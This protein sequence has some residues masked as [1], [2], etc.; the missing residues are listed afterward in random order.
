MI[1][2]FE[3]IEKII[4]KFYNNFLLRDIVYIMSG[5]LILFVVIS[6]N[7]LFDKF[8]KSPQWFKITIVFFSYYIGFL[9]Q[10][11]MII[12]GIYQMYPARSTNKFTILEKNSLVA[13]IKMMNTEGLQDNSLKR[14]DRI[15]TL[16]N[17]LA[18]FG[19][20]MISA[21]IIFSYYLMSD[22]ERII[23][24]TGKSLSTFVLTILFSC[25]LIFASII[26]NRR[27]AKVQ[28][29]IIRELSNME[30]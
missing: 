5:F 9:N 20:A 17:V 13:L 23:T 25:C 18:S 21:T 15:I 3:G 12:L 14:L 24:F 28:D 8:D 27:K 4:D 26:S 19:A 1:S 2:F 11:L 6:C 7:N 29:E 10:E 22:S 30:N 16:K